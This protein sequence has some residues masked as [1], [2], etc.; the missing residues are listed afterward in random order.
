MKKV[1]IFSI[2]ACFCLISVASAYSLTERLEGKILL[3]VE[4]RGEAWY[5]HNGLRYYMKDG[6]TAY[7]MMRFFS[8]G[9][10]NKDLEQIP[11][12]TI[13]VPVASVPE[14]IVR[15][16]YVTQIVT[17]T[18]P[19][20]CPAQIDN[21]ALIKQLQ[22]EIANLNK[23]LE[24]KSEPI[25]PCDTRI[26]FYTGSTYEKNAESQVWAENLARDLNL[27]ITLPD[28]YNKGLL[29]FTSN[30]SGI[31][32]PIDISGN[33]SGRSTTYQQ[34]STDGWLIDDNKTL[35]QR[36]FDFPTTATGTYAYSFTCEDTV[37]NVTIRIVE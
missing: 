26:S 3:Q 12:G 31:L 4:E 23:K 16:E 33:L 32:D 14:P 10:T 2:L 1:L 36:V 8:L 21:T 28:G 17:Q 30:K 35:Y 5:V 22:D 11:V 34:K 7:E 29:K 37:T 25:I 19:Q 9:I 18:V 27:S 6:A 24:P 13:E 20:T 15:T